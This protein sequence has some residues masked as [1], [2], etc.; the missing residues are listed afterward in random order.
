MLAS[1]N[2]MMAS[3][4]AIFCLDYHS[5]VVAYDDDV[6]AC[7]AVL[8]GVILGEPFSRRKLLY[9]FHARHQECI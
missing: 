3:R 6:V 8:G 7:P 1:L 9:Y 2:S 4:L 5:V